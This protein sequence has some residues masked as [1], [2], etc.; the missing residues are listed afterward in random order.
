[1]C[2]KDDKDHTRSENLIN[3]VHLVFSLQ[4]HIYLTEETQVVL[5]G[6]LFTRIASSWSLSILE[7]KTPLLTYLDQFLEEFSRTFGERHW[8]FITKLKFQTLQP[9]S[10]PTS[11]YVAEFH[12]LACDFHWNDT[13]L[14]TKFQWKLYDDINTLLVNLPISFTL[15]EVTIEAIDKDNLLLEYRKELQLLFGSYK[16]NYIFKDSCR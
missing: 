16:V 15:L 13:P 7:K 8:G 3:Q 10:C 11:T 1:M 4:P 2:D 12:Q 5:I 6:T 14:I 9:Q